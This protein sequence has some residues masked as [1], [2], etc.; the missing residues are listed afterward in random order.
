VEWIEPDGTL[1]AF[2]GIRVPG[3]RASTFAE[4]LR[5]ETGTV[6]VPGSFFEDEGHLRIG[7]GGHPGKVRAG[8]ASLR[9]SLDRLLAV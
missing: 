4:R 9:D 7:F 1:F 3:F 8:L 5:R 2:P 6:V